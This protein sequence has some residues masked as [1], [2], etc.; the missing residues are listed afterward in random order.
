[1]V[2]AGSTG[3]WLLDS[4]LPILNFTLKIRD[5]APFPTSIFDGSFR[6]IFTFLV[7]IGFVAFYPAQVFLRPDSAPLLAYASPVVGLAFFLIAYYIWEKGVQTY[8]GTGS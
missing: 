3:F 8:A 5:Y 4:S 2:I 7:P 1:M 6:F